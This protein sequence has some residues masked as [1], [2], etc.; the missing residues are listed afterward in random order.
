MTE[1]NWVEYLVEKLNKVEGIQAEAGKRLIYANEISEHKEERP[2]YNT[3]NYETDILIYEDKEKVWKPRVVIE[4][5]ISITTHDAIT[6][7]AKSATHKSVYPYLRY[8]IFIAN[9]KS[10]PGRLFRH[11]A[12]FD[13]MLSWQKCKP[14]YAEWEMLVKIIKSEIK[15]SKTLEE[16]FFNSRKQD[17]KKYYA[18]HKELKMEII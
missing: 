17:R 9:S 3:M 11:G 7:S 15:A 13:F 16:M 1:K 12:Y 5:K 2:I 8:G 6:Y 4:T 18:L 14:K 10:L